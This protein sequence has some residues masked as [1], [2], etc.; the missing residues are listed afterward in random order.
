[1]HA[2]NVVL[3]DLPITKAALTWRATNMFGIKKYVILILRY[4]EF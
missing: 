2:C 3:I 1:M 4:V